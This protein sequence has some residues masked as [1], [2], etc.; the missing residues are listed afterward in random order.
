[1]N[2][3]NWAPGDWLLVV[4]IVVPVCSFC[5]RGLVVLSKI[6]ETLAR[7][8]G[9]LEVFTEEYP[10]LS[11]RVASRVARR[12]RVRPAPSTVKISD[13]GGEHLGGAS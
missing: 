13:A 4:T 1:M 9:W 6:A 10:D 2:F 11:Q 8:D 12:P 7:L 3:W 5:A